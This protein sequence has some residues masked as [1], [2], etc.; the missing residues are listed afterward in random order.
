MAVLSIHSADLLLGKVGKFPSGLDIAL[1][2]AVSLREDDINLLKAS[3][4]GFGIEEVD[5][6]KEADV[7]DGKEEISSPANTCEHDGSDHDNEEV[8]QPVGAGREGV[9]LCTSLDRRDLCSVQ[10]WQWEPG[11]AET[12]DV[13]EQADGS[14]LS[15]RRS[16]RDQTCE[17]DCH[18]DSL[19][20][21]SV[22]EEFATS[23][24]LD[25]EPGCCGEDGIHDHV[26][27][28]KQGCHVMINTNGLLEQ[29]RE[30][31]DNSV[32]S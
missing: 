16:I 9:G 18:G 7:N 20:G 11:G 17:S 29:N 32:A 25:Q 30:E 8:E 19:A 10:P 24:S 4:G 13:C 15:G 21:C 14:T 26:D 2:L 31:V 5:Y 3:L 6:W 22:Q 12:G 27:T 1:V 28:T 23:S